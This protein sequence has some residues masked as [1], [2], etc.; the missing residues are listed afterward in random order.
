MMTNVLIGAASGIGRA[1]AVQLAARGHLILA[2]RTLESVEP[3]ADEI[4]GNVEIAA[5]DVTDPRQIEA[6]F[7]RVADLE[8]LVVTA[9]LSGAQGTAATILDVNLRGTARIMNAAEGLLRQGSVG[10]FLASASGYRTAEEPA[11]MQVLEN[12]LADDFF[13]RFAE[14]A[15]ALQSSHL[16]YSASKR[17]VMRLVRQRA[18]TWGAKGARLL[19]VSPSLVATPMS[20]NEES[21][22]PVMKKIAASS[23]IGRRGRPEEVA[24]VISFLTS[25]FAS[26]MTGSDILV[27]G[28]VALLDPVGIAAGERDG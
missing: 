19:S 11:L 7:G 27:D 9:G 15:P 22:S 26:Y 28:G 2:D 25:P 5:C 12:P 17:G 4:G 10:I 13:A 23:P 14:V 16:A 3:V 21:R 18:F 6:L 24:N 1:A 20:L 8:A